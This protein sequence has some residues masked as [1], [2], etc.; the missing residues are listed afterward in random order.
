MKEYRK[1]W[2]NNCW[3]YRTRKESVGNHFQLSSE[4]FYFATSQARLA[5][6]LGR[7]VA[8]NSLVH[9]LLS[10]DTSTAASARI[11]PEPNRVERGRTRS[12]REVRAADCQCQEG[13]QCWNFLTIYGRLGIWLL[14]RLARPHRLEELIAWNRFL[15][16]LKV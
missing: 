12:S 2:Q 9:L 4:E 8:A 13:A 6:S 10:R 1:E 7:W 11:C 3:I 5:G 14:Y 15:G 16:S